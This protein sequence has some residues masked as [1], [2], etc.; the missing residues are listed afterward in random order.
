[1]TVSFELRFIVGGPE[2]RRALLNL[3]LKW[4]KNENNQV[5]GLGRTRV[6]W[7]LFVIRQVT[8]RARCFI[9]M[10]GWYEYLR[11]YV[12]IYSSFTLENFLSLT[13]VHFIWNCITFVII[14]VISMN[15]FICMH[16]VGFN[17]LKINYLILI[18]TWILTVKVCTFWSWIY[19]NDM[20]CCNHYWNHCFN[21]GCY[22]NSS[23]CCSHYWNNYSHVVKWKWQIFCLLSHL[24]YR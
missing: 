2:D 8:S 11:M 10:T 20:H 12:Y 3:Q 22:Y 23:L 17:D 14:N 13:C 6:S 4:G 18:K 21:S 1:M 5:H 9:Y 15:S 7:L 19:C 24:F 16:F